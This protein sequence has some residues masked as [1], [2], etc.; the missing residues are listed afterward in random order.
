[1]TMNPG[2]GP[3]GPSPRLACGGVGEEEGV[4]LSRGRLRWHFKA[5]RGKSFSPF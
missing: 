5:S 2:E 1:M 4:A 3:A